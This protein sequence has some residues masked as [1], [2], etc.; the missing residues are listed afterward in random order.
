[1]GTSQRDITVLPPA[2]LRGG[3][4]PP[5]PSLSLGEASFCREQT[6]QCPQGPEGPT[7]QPVS[8]PR[9]APRKALRPRQT[10]PLAPLPG[11]VSGW[12]MA[13]HRQ[14]LLCHPSWGWD[15]LLQAEC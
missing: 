5:R 13:G 15:V 9:P 14:R 3:H 11:A 1:M 6:L 10:K 7:H 2:R 12:G 8:A 4:S